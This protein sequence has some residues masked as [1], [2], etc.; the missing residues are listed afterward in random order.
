[1]YVLFLRIDDASFLSRN[2]TSGPRWHITR[3]S[4]PESKSSLTV[5]TMSNK[6]SHARIAEL[7]DKRSQ[8][9]NIENKIEQLSQDMSKI[10]KRMSDEVAKQI[11]SS[12]NAAKAG[13]HKYKDKVSNLKLEEE[14]DA[15]QAKVAELKGRRSKIQEVINDLEGWG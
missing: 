13:R 2:P 4:Y 15:L 5:L 12:S 1:M 14:V 6:I 11:S 7:E 3:A 10:R 9:Q 8:L